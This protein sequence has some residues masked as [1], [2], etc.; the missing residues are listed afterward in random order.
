[1]IGQCQFSCHQIW[2]RVTLFVT[3][4][5]LQCFVIELDVHSISVK[6]DHD[7]TIA[8]TMTLNHKPD[9]IGC[10]QAVFSVDQELINPVHFE[11]FFYK[12]PVRY[13]TVCASV[14]MPVR[15]ENL[16]Y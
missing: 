9:D 11:L 15:E 8:L 13:C 4:L 3:V 14:M 5:P 12:L 2:C 1:M 16:P 7:M 10:C 6:S